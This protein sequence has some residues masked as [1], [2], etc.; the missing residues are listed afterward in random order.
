M[1]NIGSTVTK[2]ADAKRRNTTT[3]GHELSI[4][5]LV[6]TI[7]PLLLVAIVSYQQ[8]RSSLTQQAIDK[9][10]DSSSLVDQFIY[11]WFDFRVM[12][13]TN[14]AEAQSNLKF[15]ESLLNGFRSSGKNLVEYVHSYEWA[16]IVDGQ[17]NDLITFR[18]HYDYILDLYLI[19]LQGNILYSVGN[20]DDLGTNL[21]TGPFS[22]SMFSK[23]F[24]GTL[25]NGGVVFS[26]IEAYPVKDNTQVGFLSVP[27]VNGYGDPVGVFSVQ[28][29]ID[30]II[31]LLKK[32][33]GF[34]LTHYLV[35]EDLLLR[36]PIE[37]DRTEILQRKIDNKGIQRFITRYPIKIYSD[38]DSDSDSEE[39]HASSYPGP[40][41]VPVIGLH[42]RISVLGVNWILISE[43]EESKAFALANFL[44]KLIFLLVIVVGFS[45]TLLALY[46]ARQF[47]RPLIQLTGMVRNMSSGQKAQEITIQA[48]N[49]IGTLAE[50][51]SEM[52]N[53]RRMYEAAL[54]DA[55]HIAEDAASAK[56][57]FLAIMS[58]EIRTPMNGVLGM[59]GL[60]QQTQ[61]D[62]SQTRKVD[63]ARSSAQALLTLLNDILD[64][65][66]VD[67][68][69][70]E[71][72]EIDFNLRTHL[73]EFSES[74][75]YRAQDQG[76]EFVLDVSE[77]SHEIVKGDPGR[78]RQVLTN[79]AGNAL[80]FT[81]AGEVVI[82]ASLKEKPDDTLLFTCSVIDSGAGIPSDKISALFDPFSQVDAS[83]TRKYGGTGLGLAIVKQLCELMGGEITVSSELGKGSCFSFSLTL[84]KSKQK[85][86][87]VPKLDMSSQRIL[88]VDDNTTNREV[89][90]HQLES[91]G[92][93]VIEAASGEEA[94]RICGERSDSSAPESCPFEAAILDMHMPYMDGAELGKRLRQDARLKS[95]ALL[96]MTSLV[97]RGDTRF[98]SDLGFDAYFT[99]PY[100][101]SDLL[102]ALSIVI[103]GGEILAQANPLVTSDY[104]KTQRNIDD[105][106][107]N[108]PEDTRLL[109]VEDNNINLEVVLGML[110]RIGLTADHACNGKVALE[111][112]CDASLEN[113]YTIVLMDCQM[114][115]MDGFEATKSIRN[116]KA[117]SPNK[118]IPVVAMTANAMKGDRE[119]CLDAGMSD[120]ISKP[121]EQKELKR[122]LVKWI[123]SPES[124]VVE[125]TSSESELR[126]DRDEQDPKNFLLWD[127]Y[128]AVK[129]FGKNEAQLYRL[130]T[131]FLDEA[132]KQMESLTD[133]VNIEDY[134][135][136]EFLSHTL[137]GVSGNLCALRLQHYMTAMEV[138]ARER[139]CEEYPGLL[140]KISEACEETA[141]VMS[142]YVAENQPASKLESAELGANH[143]KE[144][145]IQ[146]D[147][148]LSSGEFIDPDHIESIL[149]SSVKGNAG[150]VAKRLLQQISS[151]NNDDALKT[152]AELCVATNIDLTS[153]G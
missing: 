95:M 47:S 29:H 64:F 22:N 19:D 92:A 67:A 127:K 94:L 37:D 2:G 71:L 117:N 45:V 84:A 85:P 65:S 110:E 119:K 106:E 105:S 147:K 74:M 114:P 100:V 89:L 118:G 7:V 143:L 40:G 33:Q 11:N 78:I 146:L 133:A 54:I 128:Q 138:A 44:G 9:L 82:K 153:R 77:L 87:F 83:T 137:K 46:K 42:K 48:N 50:A 151:F 73:E 152:L 104:L 20:N 149:I 123:L 63:V 43:Y 79:L 27:I 53:E 6:L 1:N 3:L 122:L 97:Y 57:E 116:G 103:N 32:E 56:G 55:K 61:L 91:W 112:L 69:K 102:A 107:I 120:Y 125:N 80:K 93:D 109:V 108:W 36:T 126:G 41:G 66:K 75:A 135:R 86:L 76:T 49:E 148:Q 14:Q 8:S 5:F 90:R 12:D 15:L 131:M 132:I 136:I 68:G 16:L 34:F 18:Q 81:N 145:L 35:G 98:F 134:S 124:A 70:L 21:V 139:N 30:R 4:W 38:S 72:E 17:Q 52:I 62:K 115:V 58:H 99:K 31:E 13:I 10:M 101:A 144:L 113:P 24:N 60:L 111:S 96:M 88:I 39:E 141:S 28:I 121:L 150:I 23:S 140:R 130:I 26:D 51:F 25:T 142:E 59:L 129:R